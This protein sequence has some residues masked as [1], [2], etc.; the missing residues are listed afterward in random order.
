MR[1]SGDQF[2]FI[3]TKCPD[4]QVIEA[5]KNSPLC[6]GWLVGGVVERGWSNR[7]ADLIV[8]DAKVA[9]GLP[10]YFDVIVQEKK[11]EGPSIPVAGLKAL[12]SFDFE[13]MKTGKTSSV[14]NEFYNIE[15]FKSL[16][17]GY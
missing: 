12:Q 15:D 8:S 2:R 6:E 5:I 3:V 1:F 9:E 4:V 16:K 14:S 7:D 11:P 17:Y 13:F 10:S